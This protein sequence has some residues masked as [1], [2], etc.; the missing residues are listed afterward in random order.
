MMYEAS[1]DEAFWNLA[2]KSLERAV[3]VREEYLN[4]MTID[5]A[6]EFQD[7]ILPY[8]KPELILIDD[9]EEDAA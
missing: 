4:N 5:I 8:Q 7:I 9:D 3:E 6:M 1:K 2:Q